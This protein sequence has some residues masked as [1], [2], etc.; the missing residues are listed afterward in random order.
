M[1]SGFRAGLARSLTFLLPIPNAMSDTPI[2]WSSPQPPHTHT[3][4]LTPHL[5]PPTHFNL[6][7]SLL[8]HSYTNTQ[9]TTF[10]FPTPWPNN[11]KAG[12]LRRCRFAHQLIELALYRDRD[13]PYLIF[14]LHGSSGVEF[15]DAATKLS[16]LVVL[17]FRLDK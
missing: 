5:I 10:L 15:D 17:P 14:P 9:H 4:S 6:S 8:T 12:R 7:L 3:H 2:A 13:N 11:A 1:C 16:H